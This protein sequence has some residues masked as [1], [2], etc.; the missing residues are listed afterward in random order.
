MCFQLCFLI[1][2]LVWLFDVPK[3][4]HSFLTVTPASNS[5]L[6]SITS[7]F[8]SFDTALFSPHRHTSV[9]NG[10]CFL[11]SITSTSSIPRGRMADHVFPV[12]IALIDGTLTEYALAIELRA[13]LM[14]LN[15]FIIATS[16]SKSL[17]IG[18]EDP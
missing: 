5:A 15:A 10:L 14:P 11:N 2:L 7:L 13:P 18:R 17:D 1:I 4:E 6:M 12:I 16:D 8:D 3:R 9:K